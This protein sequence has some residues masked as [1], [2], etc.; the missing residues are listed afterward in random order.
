[1]IFNGREGVRSWP[2]PFVIFELSLAEADP[3]I[4]SKKEQPVW[5]DILS[6]EINNTPPPKNGMIFQNW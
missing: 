5:R 4:T 3:A 2:N 6:S 1:M